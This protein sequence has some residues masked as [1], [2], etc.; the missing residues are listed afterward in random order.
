MIHIA[1]VVVSPCLITRP[2]FLKS[3]ITEVGDTRK[4]IRVVIIIRTGFVVD[5][6]PV[7]EHDNIQFW[8][9]RLVSSYEVHG[10]KPLVCDAFDFHQPSRSNKG[11]QVR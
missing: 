2:K 1:L 9:N 3:A 4:P 7:T 10:H 6:Q 11:V 5:D 8:K